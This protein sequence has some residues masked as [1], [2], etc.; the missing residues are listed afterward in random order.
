MDTAAHHPDPAFPRFHPRPA[1]G[2]IN[3]PNG[4][5]YV[6][7]RYH[8]FF[9]YN[10][11]SALHQSICW[12]H[13]S[14]PDLVHWDEEPVALKPQPGGPDALGCW[15]GVVTDD[16]GVPT[17]VYSGVDTLDGH[18]RVVLARADHALRTW[19]QDGHVAAEVP[20]DPQVTAVR[21]PFLFT[22]QGR[23]FALQGAGLASGH[24]AVL[25]YSV[26]DLRHWTYEGIWFSSED[27]LAARHLP[28]EIWECPQLIR[29]PDSS[30]A[31]TWV[32]MASLW[33]AADHHDHPNGVGYLL[34][35]LAAN[36]NGLPVFTP[37]SGGKADLGR[38]FY[39]PQ[40]LALPDRALLW[41]WSV[42]AED[43]EDRPGRSQSEIDDAG[44]AGILTFPR[45]LSVHGEVLAVEPA[46]ELLAYRGDRLHHGAAGTLALPAA[47]EVRVAGGEGTLRLVVVSAERRRTVF[48]DTVAGGD[49]LRIFLDASI[50]EVYRHGSVPT[51]LRAYPGPGEEWQ[52]ELP[53]GAAAD[54][55]ELRHPERP[56]MSR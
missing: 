3:D 43:R 45:Q 47:A 5:S 12:G 1:Q 50:V 9:Q 29:V 39:A 11:D 13:L 51:T 24:A 28:A 55:W 56:D 34:G 38:E 19:T 23:R 33:L 27:P 26:E 18:S 42:E 6:D 8:V 54:I 49:E 21:D 40:L 30:G 48:A 16:G 53:H 36:G 35:S 31:E 44:W 4:L 17:A 15:S 37:A 46:P 10:P 7:G 22:F 52:L 41:G 20:P 25:L 2:W 32:L 14:S